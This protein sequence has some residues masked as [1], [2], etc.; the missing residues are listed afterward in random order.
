MDRLVQLAQ[1]SLGLASCGA[2]R[3]EEQGGRRFLQTR[4]R[5]VMSSSASRA[6]CA[7]GTKR[8]TAIRPPLGARPVVPPGISAAASANT[9]VASAAKTADSARRRSRHS[10]DR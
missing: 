8:S 6:A 5:D 7:N 1:L 9:M 10:F 2:H 3:A 4:D